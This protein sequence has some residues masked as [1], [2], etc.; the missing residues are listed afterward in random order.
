MT[1][2]KAGSG[3][4]TEIRGPSQ[5]AQN[6][7]AVAK[8]GAVLKYDA[9][10]LPFHSRCKFSILTRGY[11]SWT[12]LSWEEL[13]ILLATVFRHSHHLSNAK[14]TSAANHLHSLLL[15]VSK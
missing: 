12:W 3:D 15:M 1:K 2:R 10:F 4:E 14:E 11:L 9:I 6:V 7:C 13:I 5:D 8:E